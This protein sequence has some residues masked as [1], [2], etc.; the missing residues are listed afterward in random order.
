MMSSFCIALDCITS[1]VSW[2]G[3]IGV[4]AFDD[5]YWQGVS[6][7]SVVDFAAVWHN[8]E[9]HLLSGDLGCDLTTVSS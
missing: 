4:S 9:C 6:N 2:T 7:G 8:L 5:D 3:K 1:I